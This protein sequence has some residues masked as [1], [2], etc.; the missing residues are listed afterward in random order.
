MP[1]S[2]R[3]E[4][5]IQIAEKGGNDATL[6]LLDTIHTLEDNLES[7]KEQMYKQFEKLEEKF[8]KTVNEIKETMPNLD[9]VLKSVKGM[10]GDEG[11]SPTN[12]ELITIIEPLIPEPIKGDDYVLTEKDKKE[13]AKSIPVPV[14]EKIIEKTKTIVEQPIVTNEIKEIA[15]ADTPEQIR[16]KLETLKE[17]ARLDKDAIKGLEEFQKK[18]DSMNE[19]IGGMARARGGSRRSYE[20][21]RVRLTDQVDGQQRRFNLPRDTVS[22]IGIFSSQFPFTADDVDFTLEGNTLVFG[23][24]MPTVVAG[25][26]LV[27]ICEVLFN[28]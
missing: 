11:H 4:R 20:T 7:H 25:Q 21:R 28:I 13:I 23:D 3:E 24:E 12:E 8:E 5:L 27:A 17:E 1:L 6:L 16:G 10:P 15:L 18:L 9:D 19:R 22:I 2:P 26:T 14:V